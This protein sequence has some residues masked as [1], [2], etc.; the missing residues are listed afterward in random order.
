MMYTTL[1]FFALFSTYLVTRQYVLYAISKESGSDAEQNLTLLFSVI[2]CLCWA[3]YF[4][5]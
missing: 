1:L 3:L 4:T 2:G 5:L